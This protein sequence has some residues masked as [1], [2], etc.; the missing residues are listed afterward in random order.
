MKGIKQSSIQ[1]GKALFH[2]LAQGSLSQL[3]GGNL[4][5]GFLGG[6]FTYLIARSIFFGS[7]TGNLRFYRVDVGRLLAA[8]VIGLVVTFLGRGLILYGMLAAVLQ[9]AYNQHQLKQAKTNGLKRRLHYARN[10][11]NEREIRM[12]FGDRAIDDP[13]FRFDESQLQELG[14]LKAKSHENI[15]HAWGRGN[16]LNTKWL[17]GGGGGRFGTI[18][19]ITD[20]ELALVLN[21]QLIGTYN[22]GSTSWDHFV[23]DVLPYIKYGNSPEDPTNAARRILRLLYGAI[24]KLIPRFLK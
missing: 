7:V 13:G 3:I 10:E 9:E 8:A 14:F 23:K 15:F 6:F 20:A 1:L 19:I 11:K 16:E 18:E 4:L 5:S 24:I 21:P 22:Y 17:M 12:L 2:G